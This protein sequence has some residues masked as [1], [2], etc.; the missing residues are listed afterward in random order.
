VEVEEGEPEAAVVEEGVTRV[1]TREREVL[2]PVVEHQCPAC[3]HWYKPVRRDQ[4]YCDRAC[5]QSGH[6]Q[7]KKLR[8][9]EVDGFHEERIRS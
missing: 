5:K 9:A 2:C 3:G 7:R 8:A 1:Q 4:V 6:R